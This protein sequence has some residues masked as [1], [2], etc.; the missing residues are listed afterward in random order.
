MCV[1]AILSFVSSR[2]FSSQDI[3][4]PST[5]APAPLFVLRRFICHVSWS[6]SL[7]VNLHF[8]CIQSVCLRSAIIMT[9]RRRIRRRRKDDWWIDYWYLMPNQ[10]RG[11]IRAKQTMISQV[12]THTHTTTT[13][14]DKTKKKRR[15]KKKPLY[16]INWRAGMGMGGLCSLV[17]VGRVCCV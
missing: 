16:N 15:M 2:Y 3:F 12:K 7:S 11:Y 4:R 13:G 6:A 10:P 5:L 8:W 1:C 9:I 17:A 14:E